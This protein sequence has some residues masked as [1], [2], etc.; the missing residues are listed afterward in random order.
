MSD[1]VFPDGFLFGTA[2]A[3]VQIEG[4]DRNNSWYR[5]SELGK[6]R[7]GSHSI[8]ACDHWNRVEQDIGLM[9]RIHSGTYRM[10]VEW[11]RIEPEE[12]RFD[13][14]ALAAYRRELELLREAGIVPLVT[15]HHFSNP[16]WLEDSGAFG[17]PDIVRIF[18]RYAEVVYR[19]LGDLCEDWV[20]INE[21]NVYLVFGYLYGFWPPGKKNPIAFVRRARNMIRC[22]L[23]A[24]DRMHRIANRE[25]RRVRVGVAH[26]LRIFDSEHGNSAERVLSRIYDR[27]FQDL[28][29]RGTTE[30]RVYRPF[31]P[32]EPFGPPG[33]DGYYADFLGLNYYT[34]DVLG[35]HLDP[36]TL[37]VRFGTAPGAAV[38]DLGWEL[39]P[40]GLFRLGMALARR[41]DLP[42]WITEN[43]TCDAADAF[44]SEY[45]VSHLRQVLRLIRHGARV[46]RY[47]HWSLMDNFEWIEGVSARFGLYEVDF[48]TQV[49]RLR[50]S[51]R[52]YGEISRTGRLPDA[53]GRTPAAGPVQGDEDAR[54]LPLDSR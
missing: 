34:R 36:R 7:D 45:I 52:L 27:Y 53:V 40:Q 1:S 6:I 12:G 33:P 44:R 21:P 20:T 4:G 9:R 23:A 26:H 47:Y 22:H 43:G 30:G 15:L 8:V 51:G 35:F 46:E 32:V 24:Y 39:Y 11:S 48:E 10:G 14:E 28:F 54:A 13:S 31:G 16:L 19:A 3:A 17:R 5:W 41:Y 49:R 29:L 2:T 37:F 50:P 18:R 25:G 42:L 38:N